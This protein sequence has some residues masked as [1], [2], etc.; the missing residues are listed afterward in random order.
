MPSHADCAGQTSCGTAG[1]LGGSAAAH[2]ADEHQLHPSALLAS[3]AV[4]AG[5]LQV[6][7]LAGQPE[8]W[9]RIEGLQYY[10]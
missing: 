1:W 8:C 6:L 9:M 10:C 7:T 2:A 3:V 4:P 5:S